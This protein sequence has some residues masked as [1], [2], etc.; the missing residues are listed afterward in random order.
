MIPCM[1][2]RHDESAPVMYSAP[3]SMCRRTLARPMAT[4]T[5]FSSTE[6]I[7]PKP[8]H[9]SRRSGSMTSTPSTSDSRSRSFER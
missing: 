3:V 5:A 1:C 7:P 8:Q 6:N 2:I 4:E 9:S